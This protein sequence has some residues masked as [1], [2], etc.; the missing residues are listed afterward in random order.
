MTIY[1]IAGRDSVLRKALYLMFRTLQ[2]ENRS[3]SLSF[4]GLTVIA[5]GDTNPTKIWIQYP[6]FSSRRNDHWN[7]EGSLNFVLSK[8][9]YSLG[10]LTWDR[11]GKHVFWHE[12]HLDLCVLSTPFALSGRFY[13]GLAFARTT[14]CWGRSNSERW[15]HTS[16]CISC[17][18]RFRISE[19][20]DYFIHR[21]QSVPTSSNQ[22][23]KLTYC[24]LHRLWSLQEPP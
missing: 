22:S 2:E 4:V 14:V 7:L 23:F 11:K 16:Q 3:F 18:E 15:N 1:C 9:S 24:S 5:F 19:T 21:R 12:Q 20:I 13:Q 8:G 6:E 17:S 10:W